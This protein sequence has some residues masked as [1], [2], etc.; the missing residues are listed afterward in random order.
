M[1]TTVEVKWHDF[2]TYQIRDKEYE[3]E[4]LARGSHWHQPAVLYYKDGSGSPEEDEIDVD[5]VTI[6]SVIYD[7][8]D[9]VNNLSQKLIEKLEEEITDKIYDGDYEPI[10]PPDPEDYEP[11]EPEEW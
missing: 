3:V 10:Y 2:F 5:E 11:E 4:F 9:I 7:G 6:E 1:G 8:E